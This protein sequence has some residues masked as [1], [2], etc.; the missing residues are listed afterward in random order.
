MTCNFVVLLY[1]DPI[2]GGDRVAVVDRNGAF[3]GAP[4]WPPCELAPRENVMGYNHDRAVG[5][6]IGYNTVI[7][8]VRYVEKH[9]HID[10]TASHHVRRVLKVIYGKELYSYYR[11]RRPKLRLAA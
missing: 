3:P 6:V 2:A 11:Y 5:C 10:P 7:K 9:G 4:A 1:S 8:A